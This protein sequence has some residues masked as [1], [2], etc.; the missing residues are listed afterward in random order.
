MVSINKNVL[1]E[2]AKNELT[3]NVNLVRAKNEFVA[4]R[5]IK[6]YKLND[7]NETGNAFV[8]ENGNEKIAVLVFKESGSDAEE[9]KRF[10][11]IIRYKISTVISY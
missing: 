6:V 2:Y 5:N 10:L 4:R 8:I 1:V 11:S 7:K 3:K 9:L